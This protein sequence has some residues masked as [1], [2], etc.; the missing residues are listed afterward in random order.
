MWLVISDSMW[1]FCCSDC[2]VNK[3][4]RS[5]TSLLSKPIYFFL[6]TSLLQEYT[7]HKTETVQYTLQAYTVPYTTHSKAFEN[8]D[9][10]ED[11]DRAET[12]SRGEQGLITAEN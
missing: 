5:Q 1:I 10:S 2:S 11:E 12:D 4:L 9:T 6:L 7:V 3:T 8:H